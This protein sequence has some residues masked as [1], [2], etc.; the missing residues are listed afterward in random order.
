M[1][2]KLLIAL[3]AFI[4]LYAFSDKPAE[5]ISFPDPTLIINGAPIVMQYGDALS[6]SLP[7]LEALRDNIMLP[8]GY[9]DGTF[10]I[11]TTG[12]FIKDEIII[13]TGQKGKPFVTNVPDMDGAMPAVGNGGGGGSTFDSLINYWGEVVNPADTW[14]QA[15]YWDTSLSAFIGA[16]ITPTNQKPTNA[17]FLF[18]NNQTGKGED[19]SLYA[20]ARITFTG[21][22]GQVDQVYELIDEQTPH[23]PFDF[24][25]DLGEPSDPGEFVHVMG[26]NTFPLPI[27]GPINHNLGTNRAAYAIYFPEINLQELWDEGYDAMH[28]DIRFR[29]L[30]DGWEQIV[31][32]KDFIPYSE[33]GNG[34]PEPGTL[35]LLGSGLIGLAI[36]SRRKL[37][38]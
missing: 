22:S 7:Y 15:G 29:G 16:L 34:I 18:N 14:D 24:K 23:G 5:A 2:K 9:A 19:Q 38:G 13:Y 30:N 27:G 32:L 10:E 11:Q 37:K 26:E 25:W 4:C 33:N 20:Y 12:N 36:Y 28:G 17:M 3:I 35:V 31:V 21:S 6:Y 8:G 1:R